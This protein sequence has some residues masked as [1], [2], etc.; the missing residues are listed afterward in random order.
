MVVVPVAAVAVMDHKL[1]RAIQNKHSLDID[2]IVETT[3][4][5]KILR[6]IQKRYCFVTHNSRAR[7]YL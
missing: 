6:N 4:L 7:S 1:L 3:V 5:Y 2:H